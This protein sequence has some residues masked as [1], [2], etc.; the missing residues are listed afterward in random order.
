[1]KRIRVAIIIKIAVCIM[2]F[3]T[4]A[5]ATLVTLD[6]RFALA[7]IAARQGG[8]HSTRLRS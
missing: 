1:M 2:Y 3:I 4:F 6:K 7:N 8:M 5:N